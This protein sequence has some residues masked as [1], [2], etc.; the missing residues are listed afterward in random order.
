MTEELRFLTEEVQGLIE[1]L[2]T[3]MSSHQ[4]TAKQFVD[5]QAYAGC[6]EKKIKS[7][8]NAI[9]HGDEQHR[10]WLKEA[11]DKHFRLE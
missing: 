2:K 8:Y 5:M 6:L 10:A 11:I 9:A 3:E 4:K 7:L 1:D